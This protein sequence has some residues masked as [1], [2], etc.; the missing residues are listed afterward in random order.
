MIIHFFFKNVFKS[1]NIFLFHVV[2]FYL[3][4]CSFIFNF[5]FIGSSFWAFRAFFALFYY[6]YLRTPYIVLL[7]FILMFY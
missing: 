7:A 5:Y 1:K 4:M 6:I 2:Q 3:F